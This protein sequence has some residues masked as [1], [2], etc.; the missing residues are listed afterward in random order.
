M[1][2]TAPLFLLAVARRSLRETR[3]FT[4]QVEGTNLTKRP[5]TRI[6]APPHRNRMLLLAAIWMLT[7]ACTT[8]AITFWKE[9]AMGE[10]AYTE[11][12]VGLYISI[13][14]VAGMPFAFLAA[15]WLD[16]LGRRRASV[17]IYLSVV[18]GTAGCYLAAPPMLVLISLVLAMGGITATGSVLA[19][20]NAELF[21]TELRSDAF[22]WSN[23]LFGRTAQVV[24]PVLV[25]YAAESVGWA[26]AV[27]STVVF[28]ALALAL[29]L[30][31]L[32]E[33][34]GRELEDI[35]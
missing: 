22:G 3:R 9:H 8:N 20:Y 15:K 27:A 19:A 26:K 12:R 34:R 24:T 18:A 5:F 35:A 13:A 2:G 29:I 32:P 25:G 17:L 28:P 4:E 33:T 7:Y 11:G 23:H 10:R 30:L 1:L 16:T 14:A 31:T 6:L 21:P